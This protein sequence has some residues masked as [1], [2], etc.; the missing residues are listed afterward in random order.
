MKDE[1]VIMLKE[2]KENK[3]IFWSLSVILPIFYVTIL[4]GGIDGAVYIGNLL[5]AYLMECV[6]YFITNWIYGRIS[7]E[8]TKNNSISLMI[9]FVI[10]VLIMVIQFRA[11]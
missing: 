11:I 4:N 10:Y 7:K 6:F 3:I 8:V 2:L 5:G 9:G 1:E